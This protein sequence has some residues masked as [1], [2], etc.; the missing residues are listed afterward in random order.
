MLLTA[1]RVGFNARPTPTRFRVRRGG[2]M[3]V[4]PLAIGAAAATGGMTVGALLAY[5][6]DPRAGR[7]R[8]HTARDR[9]MSRVRRGERRVA[10][11]ARRAESHA[12]GIARRTLNAARSRHRDPYD[13]VTL[14]RKVEKRA[15]SPRARAEGPHQHQRRG[16]ARVPARRH[17]PTAGH[18]A[19]RGRDT[20]DRGRSR[21]GEPDPPARHA[22][23]GEPPEIAA[24]ALEQRVSV[25][26]AHSTRA[27]P[28][29]P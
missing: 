18:R 21:G 15:P 9:A 23:A 13:D 11:R 25:M 22:G 12:V 19:H 2:S 5:F 20:A 10:A 16:W 1:P 29:R 6:L 7:R 27:D 14:A 3:D 24:S 28:R 8:R 17:G 4:N 26:L